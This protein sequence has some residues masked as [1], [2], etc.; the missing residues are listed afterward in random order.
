MSGDNSNFR[1]RFAGMPGSL[2]AIRVDYARRSAAFD[3]VS[4]ES[5]V[6]QAKRDVKRW[7]MGHR[8]G[9]KAEWNGSNQPEG[10]IGGAPQRPNLRQ[11][12]EFQGVKLEYNYR[13][14]TLPDIN[15]TTRYVSKPSKLQVDRSIF[16]PPHERA[17]LTESNMGTRTMLSRKEMSNT[18]VEGEDREAGWNC[19]VELGHER[20][21]I[22]KLRSYE[23]F[24]ELNKTKSILDHS[25]YV[26]PH[27]RQ[28][29]TLKAS[30]EEK[31]ARRDDEARAKA[32]RD[33]ARHSHSAPAHNALG[34]NGPVF[35][36]SNINQWWDDDFDRKMVSAASAVLG[37]PVRVEGIQPAVG[38]AA[39]GARRVEDGV[40]IAAT[41]TVD[42]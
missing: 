13:A 1:S 31:L 12:S 22:Y 6:A 7:K 15:K 40:D 35:K 41:G 19:S 14:A 29:A 27:K 17:L 16:L 42:P 10:H 30:R 2:M 11:L 18:G 39:G 34:G 33:A 38:G 8:L 25:T 5:E 20:S 37:R 4:S 24:L 21:D 32:L 36:M 26:A 28:Q 9:D 3:G 23:Q